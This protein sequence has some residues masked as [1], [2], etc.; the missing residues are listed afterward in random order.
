VQA[1]DSN[2]AV[3]LADHYIRGDG[4][5]V[6]CDQA[7][8]LLLVASEKNNKAAIQKLRDLDKTG[9]PKTQTPSQ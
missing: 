7:R 3:I 1:G 8:V 4:V 5:P 9:C 2:A 6:N